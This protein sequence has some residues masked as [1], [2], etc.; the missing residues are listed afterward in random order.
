M[1][2]TSLLSHQ[3][4]D[5]VRPRIFNH[6]IMNCTHEAVSGNY[7]YGGRAL[8]LTEPA[9]II[10]LHPDLSSEWP[11][12]TA[13]YE[14]IG[15]SHS[16]TAIWNVSRHRL[17]QFPI[18]DISVFYFGDAMA[19]HS[20]TRD[21]FYHL[22]PQWCEVVEYVNCKNSF[23]Q[24]A[25]ILEIAIPKTMRFPSKAEIERFDFLP[26]P[27]YVKPAVS[28]NGVGITRCQNELALR[29]ALLNIEENVPLQVQQEIVASKFL[30]LQYQAT[31]QGAERLAATEQ[32]LDGCAHLGNRYPTIHQ[33]WELVDPMAHWMV[34]QGMK[35]IFAFDVA[36]VEQAGQTH[37]FAIECNPRFNGASYPTGIARK[38][39]ISEW[40]NES[41]KTDHRSLSTIDLTGLEYDSSSGSGVIVV[42]WGSVLVGKLGILIAG[43]VSEQQV[44][45]S[46]LQDR[47]KQ[48]VLQE[49]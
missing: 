39:G 32:I 28:V 45:R 3:G 4:G 5:L 20:P 34:N 47:L 7:L 11:F 38:L 33:P 40:S 17:T 14:R 27:C 1:N 9:D 23:T 43:S 15:L 29:Q 41:F 13:H 8:G 16:Q 46:H 12:I 37:Y 19:A 25:E 48:R 18:C 42:N 35:G 10:Q 31:E 26:Y 30:N 24:L 49:A 2:S 36:V 6:D 44:I 21:W 22:D